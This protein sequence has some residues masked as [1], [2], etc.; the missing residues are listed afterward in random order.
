MRFAEDLEARRSE[1]GDRGHRGLEVQDRAEVAHVAVQRDAVPE[2]GTGC[3]GRE[4]DVLGHA[5]RAG[6]VLLRDVRHAQ[7]ELDRQLVHAVGQTAGERHG[8][9]RRVLERPAH[10]VAVPQLGERVLLSLQRPQR[11]VGG[12]VDE[13]GDAH[14]D[15]VDEG[16]GHAAVRRHAD[17][18]LESGDLVALAD[19]AESDGLDEVSFE[20]HRRSLSVGFAFDATLLCLIQT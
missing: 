17:T 19:V 18:E 7:P 16:R 2:G 1:V 12:D 10:A 11:H 20:K 8:D 4:R 14:A 9:D 5:V 15:P 6:L 3:L 13:P